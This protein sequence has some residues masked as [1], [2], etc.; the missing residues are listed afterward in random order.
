MGISMI[1][2]KVPFRDQGTKPG[3]SFGV[4]NGCRCKKL[5]NDL[6]SAYLADWFAR[7]DPKPA[8]RTVQ[9]DLGRG[10]LFYEARYASCHGASA[11]R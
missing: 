6:E 8:V 5:N 9:G 2:C 11:G 4:P 1:S 7:Q 10:K 3:E